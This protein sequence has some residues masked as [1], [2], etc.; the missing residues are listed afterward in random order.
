MSVSKC[1]T[2]VRSFI[3]FF[4]AQVR[5]CSYTEPLAGPAYPFI[6][7][8][9]STVVVELSRPKTAHSFTSYCCGL[10]SVAG[11]GGT[12]RNQKLYFANRISH[13]N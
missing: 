1:S 4:L 9:L 11:V 7:K 10:G 6:T 13:G 3:A 5:L 8:A 2:A 12:G